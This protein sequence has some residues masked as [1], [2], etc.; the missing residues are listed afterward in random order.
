MRNALV[1]QCNTLRIVTNALQRTATRSKLS[2]GTAICRK[3]GVHRA[4]AFLLAHAK[5]PASG[6]RIAEAC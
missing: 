2:H 3:C 1:T 6:E 5:A 4:S